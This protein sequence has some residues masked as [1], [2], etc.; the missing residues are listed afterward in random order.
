MIAAD[1][2]TTEMG[3]GNSNHFHYEKYRLKSFDVNGW[4]HEQINPKI[5]AKTGFYYTGTP[6]K[7]K[8]FFCTLI[9][10]WPQ[11]MNDKET[12]ATHKLR[13]PYCRFLRRH[14]NTSNVPLEPIS[15]LNQ[16]L[17]SSISTEF[18]IPIDRRH[19]AYTETNITDNMKTLKIAD[20][21][22]Y[23]VTHVC[24]KI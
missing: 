20:N 13:S 10:N 15:E 4:P 16:L 7:V 21:N 2:H 12:V 22:R 19:G 18:N 17:S 9:I 3:N 5:L 6:N 24:M 23:K 14:N 11:S 8:C 1:S